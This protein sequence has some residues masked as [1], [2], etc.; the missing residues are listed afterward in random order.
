MGWK[1]F[2]PALDGRSYGAIELPVSAADETGEQILDQ[3]YR[4]TLAYLDR[5]YVGAVKFYQLD[6]LLSVWH[7]PAALKADLLDVCKLYVLLDHFYAR[8]PLS[9]PI[10]KRRRN[11]ELHGYLKKRLHDGTGDCAVAR[12]KAV[13]ILKLMPES[14]IGEERLREA[15]FRKIKSA[16]A[17]ARPAV[18]FDLKIAKSGQAWMNERVVSDLERLQ[19]HLDH[20]RPQIMTY[21][22]ETSDYGFIT[23]S[24][25]AYDYQVLKNMKM[26]VHTYDPAAG[27]IIKIKVDMAR[28]RYYADDERITGFYLESYQPEAVPVDGWMRI[29]KALFLIQAYWYLRRLF[30]RW[31]GWLRRP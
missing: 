27:R 11:S 22:V 8:L 5:H 4:D 16:G 31:F 18:T 29:L 12:L 3:A 7:E 10:R 23:S 2:S 15:I 25:I 6:Q 21:V 30:H 1:D 13:A 26:H 14:W 20:H 17:V 24:V 28:S 19:D 9:K